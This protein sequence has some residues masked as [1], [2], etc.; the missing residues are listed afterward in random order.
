MEDIRKILKFPTKSFTYSLMPQTYSKYRLTSCICADNIY[1]QASLRRNTGA[2][3]QDDLVKDFKLWKFKLIVTVD[4]N[5]SIKLTDKVSK[6]ISKAIVIVNNNNIHSS[7]KFIEL[8]VLNEQVIIMS[9]CLHSLSHFNSTPQCPELMINLLELIFHIGFCNYATAGLKPQ[10]AVSRDKGADDNGL[11][12]VTREADEANASPVSATIMR[13]K[14]RNN[15]HRT[16]FWSPRKS[17][18]RESVDKGSYF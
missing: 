10:F 8:H 12:E 14:F 7:F 4:T 18:S 2:W 1:Q 15:L 11:I 9:S 16:H 3:R 13:F 6:V 17:S 5:T